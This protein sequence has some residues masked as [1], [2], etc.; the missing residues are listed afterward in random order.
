[1]LTVPVEE[2]PPIT[3]AGLTETAESTGGLIVSVVFCVPL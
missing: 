3:L 1:M 2:L